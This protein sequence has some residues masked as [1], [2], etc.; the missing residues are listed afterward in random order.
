VVAQQSAVPL[1]V[2]AAVAIGTGFAASSMFTTAQLRYSLVNPGLVYCVITV[3]G[4]AATMPL[5][6]RIT[7][8]GVARNE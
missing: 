1:P 5:L 7:G 6:R 2:T 8:P 3:A 4:I